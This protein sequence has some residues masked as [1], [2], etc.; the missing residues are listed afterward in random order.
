MT[1]S[2]AAWERL[3]SHSSMPSSSV[4]NST[5]LAAPGWAAD[6]AALMAARIGASGTRARSSGLVGDCPCLA[7]MMMTVLPAS[8]CA[9]IS[10]TMRK[11][12]P[13]MPGTP[14]LAV[15]PWLYGPSNIW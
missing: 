8:P 15:R 2:A 12:I 6:Q 14:I 13:K 5:R 4:E 7:E 11:F 9:R 1:K 10:D 3:L